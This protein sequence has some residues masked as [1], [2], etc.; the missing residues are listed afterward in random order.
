MASI[1]NR[2]LIIRRFRDEEQAPAWTFDLMVCFPPCLC[3]SR[4]A[5]TLSKRRSDLPIAD[6]AEEP[7]VVKLAAPA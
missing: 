1:E 6:F 7:I 5:R 2:A 3:V 4:G